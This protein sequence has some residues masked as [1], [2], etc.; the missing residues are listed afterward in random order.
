MRPGEP[1]PV[2]RRMAAE[3]AAHG[4]R[5]WCCAPGAGHLLAL[6]RLQGLARRLAMGLLLL[7]PVLAG[8][9]PP[10]ATEWPPSDR[11]R[12]PEAPPARPLA[13]A[14]AAH[15]RVGPFVA[16]HPAWWVGVEPLSGS[17]ARAFGPGERLPG[18]GRLPLAARLAEWLEIN[19]EIVPVP[20]DDLGPV[21]MLPPDMGGGV[22]WL[23]LPQRHLGRPVLDA[24]LTVAVRS[25]HVVYVAAH[26]VAPVAAPDR[27]RLDAA[28]ALAAVQAEAGGLPLA[29]AGEA[30]LAYATRSAGRGA[31][32]RLAHRLVWT[33]QVLPA[34]AGRDALHHAQ[35]DAV[36][37]Q[38]VALYPEALHAGACEAEPRSLRGRVTGGVRPN[39]ADDPEEIR[40]LPW[41]LVEE[42]GVLKGA[43][44]AGEYPYGGG[45]AASRLDGLNFDLTCS[46]CAGQALAGAGPA[47]QVAFGTGGGSLGSPVA[48]NGTSTPAERSVFYHLQQS[49]Q[50]LDKWSVRTFPDITVLVNINQTCN[51]SS[52]EYRLNFYKE[53]NGCRNTAEVRD[54]VHH[55]LGH[56]WDRFDGV[57]ITNSLRAAAS[58]WKG[59]MV[60]V[61]F[62]GD[63]CMGESFYMD[64]SAFA[65][66]GCSGARDLDETSPGRLDLPLTPLEC[67]SCATLKRSDQSAVCGSSTHCAGMIAGQ[68]V[69]HLKQNLLAGSDFISGA[70]LPPGNPALS[71]FQAAWLLEKLLLR[72]G[73]PIRTW[74]PTTSGVSIYDALMVEDDDDLD[75]G[76]GTPHAAYINAAFAHH[77]LDETP[78]ITDSPNCAAPAD[79]LLTAVLE[80]RPGAGGWQVRVDWSGGGPGPFHVGR[81][82]RAGDTFLPVAGP[83]TAG[84]VIDPA[85][86]P[87]ET[88]EYLVWAENGSSCWMVSPGLA[89]VTVTIAA[90]ALDVVSVSAVE[91]GGDGDGSV[92]PGE[93][94]DLTVTL[95]ETGGGA[96]VTGLQ[97][98]LISLDRSLGVL[99]PG[100]VA[101]GSLPS[102]G[103]GAGAAAFRVALAPD[104]PC[105]G[106]VELR[107]VASA[108]EGCW[109]LRGHLDL[110]VGGCDAPG[111]P[112]VRPVAGSLAPVGDTGDGDGIP[113]NCELTSFSYRLVNAGTAPSGPFTAEVSSLQPQAAVRAGALFRHPGLAPGQ[114]ATALFTVDVAGA[115]P[116]AP[117]SFSVLVDSPEGGRV[118]QDLTAVAEEDP[119]TYGAILYDFESGGQGW[120]TSGFTWSTARAA[121]G[122]RSFHAG[123]TSRSW[124]C[125]WLRSP[126]LRVAPGGG[127]LDLQAY[128]DVESLSS[129]T[130]WD[131][132]N[133]HVID[134]ASG[135]HV[136]VAPVSGL[137]Y[138][139]TGGIVGN[140]CHIA[141]Q[142]GWAGNLAPFAPASFDLTP[143]AGREIQIEINYAS[144]GSVN[145]EG[146]YVD[147]IL[148]AGVSLV[149]GDGQGDGCPLVPEVSP[150]GSPVPLAVTPDAG[151][152]LFTWEDLGPGHAYHLYAGATGSWYSHGA[153]PLTCGSA[154]VSCDGSVCSFTAASLPA[155][156]QAYFVVTAS[157]DGRQ[158]PSGFTSAGLPRSPGQ[159]TCPP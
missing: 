145:R 59:D 31:S 134:L 101:Y 136:P 75:L 133:V 123:S 113:D 27:P 83:V 99:D 16:R 151:G 124:L 20:V 44:A 71:P 42:E 128:V 153:T 49:R 41:A 94:A 7:A 100:P 60:A 66:T 98:S 45:A 8:S 74:D 85:V 111:R 93:T 140:I 95:G 102:G 144:D 118:A 149:P 76:N 3:R 61:L 38:V 34:G 43:D 54:V 109:P 4:R 5:R 11:I 37:G 50:M 122:A 12:R 127:S 30:K 116:S 6:A 150:P 92:E 129:A 1:R 36:S 89:P 10:A 115:A 155:G 29:L 143:W 57:D 72:A 24:D 138:N 32:L 79:P 110:G 117:L 47:G 126:R 130:W 90:P 13:A 135:A 28:A 39:R 18:D 77:E 120:I 69:W 97:A 25:D 14:D 40:A 64:S 70:P 142:G 53:G 88:L 131:R 86:A 46:D 51:A 106:P 9:A 65:S 141:Q 55:E 146:I 22:R 147:D 81:R 121:S 108:D 62:G 132:A 26:G 15:P 23:V 80:P 33:L 139:A 152:A 103:S 84:P 21:V 19:P 82:W 68:A 58:E 52:G 154:G 159:D 157:R 158:G 114:E 17:V 107:L 2:G 73:P 87:G 48:G 78:A 105:P 96:G 137:L 67:P 35:V 63:A 148:L 104:A 112:F 119:P 156:Q 91:V 125:S 56:T